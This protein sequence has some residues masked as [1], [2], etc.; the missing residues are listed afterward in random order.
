MTSE[1]FDEFIEIFKKKEDA[2][3]VYF[4]QKVRCAS[5]WIL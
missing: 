2:I 4:L 5:D 1:L 3:V